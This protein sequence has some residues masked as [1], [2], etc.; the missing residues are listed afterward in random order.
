VLIL[1]NPAVAGLA[2]QL[3][4]AAQVFTRREALP[5]F[6]L[7]CPIMSLPLRMATTLDNIPAAQAIWRWMRPADSIG[8]RGKKRCVSAWYGQARRGILMTASAA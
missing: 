2:S 1:L 3:L 6:D 8:L 5:A 4:P 7:H